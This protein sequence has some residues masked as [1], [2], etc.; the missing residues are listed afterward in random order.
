MFIS[1]YIQFVALYKQIT[2]KRHRWKLLF[3]FSGYTSQCCCVEDSTVVVFH[4]R[5]KTLHCWG[6]LLI[7]ILC[8]SEN[9]PGCQWL[10]SNDGRPDAH[11]HT[12]GPGRRNKQSESAAG[13]GLYLK[14]KKK[15]CQHPPPCA[16]L[17][18]GRPCS[19]DARFSRTRRRVGGRISQGNFPPDGLGCGEKHFCFSNACKGHSLRKE[20]KTQE[21]REPKSCGPAKCAAGKVYGET[22]SIWNNRK[23]MLGCQLLQGGLSLLLEDQSGFTLA[24][25]HHHLRLH[26]FTRRESKWVQQILSD[27]REHD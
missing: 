20:K 26:L 16:A 14:F 24:G 12:G 18:P 8:K 10:S 9:L 23:D 4:S 19:P 11:V 7:W 22:S 21:G 2:L 5:C 3:F 25:V 15:S 17:K 1:N 6:H 13:E 27:M